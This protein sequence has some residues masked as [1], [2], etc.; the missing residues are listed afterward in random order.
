MPV[1]FDSYDE[2]VGRMDLTEGSNAHAILT[3]LAS[4]P[5]TG[6]TPAEIHEE[7]GIPYGSVGPTLQR[8]HE[9]DLVRHKEPYWAIGEKRELARLGVLS[10]SVEAIDERLGREDPETWLEN[11]EPVDE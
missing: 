10:A 1:R 4:N 9:R 5:E 6:Y 8:L 2:D 7:T 3:F 11:A